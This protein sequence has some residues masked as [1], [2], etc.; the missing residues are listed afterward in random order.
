[1]KKQNSLLPSGSSTADD[2]VARLRE[3]DHLPLDERVAVYNSVTAALKEFV[4]LPH[5]CLAPQL[6]PTDSV[7]ANDYN[8]NKVA[9]PELSLLR[10]SIR[11][12]GLTMPVVVAD[13][14]DAGCTVVDGFH[15]RTIAASDKQVRESL[16]GYLP[17]VKLNK[18]L[19]D[20]IA[21]TVRHNMARGA[22]QTEL[23]AK[24]I[25]MLRSHDWSDD[26]IAKELGMQ[27][28][29]VLRLKQV[30]GLAEAFSDREFS[31]AWEADTA[32]EP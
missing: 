8:P 17:V 12:D 1:M 28:D 30:T 11:K 4:G 26:R 27:S 18:P 31:R 13:S 19:E 5:P 14:P 32:L 22:H 16:E 2:I 3:C 15:R 10:V 23:S 24:L 29:E 9:P 21:A 20:R 7:Q 6:V 25:L